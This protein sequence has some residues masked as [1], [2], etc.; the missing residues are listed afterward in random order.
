MHSNL[1]VYS[2]TRSC[3][4]LTCSSIVA[5]WL[6][7]LVLFS[8]YPRYNPP[9]GKHSCLTTSGRV[10]YLSNWFELEAVA[11]NLLFFSLTN[12]LTGCKLF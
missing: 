4:R 2:I 8:S 11:L 10:S 7:K 9:A 3:T 5:N 12:N 6:L 1:L